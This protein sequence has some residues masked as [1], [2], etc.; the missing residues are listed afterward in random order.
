MTAKKTVTERN[1]AAVGK[2][3][4]NDIVERRAA[5]SKFV[6]YAERIASDS[7]ASRSGQASSPKL[8]VSLSPTRRKCLVVVTHSLTSLDITDVM[9]LSAKKY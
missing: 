8:G 3:V 1:A 4:A 7:D 5:V 9:R 2:G 6:K